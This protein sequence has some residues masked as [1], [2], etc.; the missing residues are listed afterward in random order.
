[1]NTGGRLLDAVR[2]LLDGQE[3]SFAQLVNQGTG[4]PARPLIY[5]RS[6]IST[7]LQ[8]HLLF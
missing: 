7:L 5:P 8:P 2:E 6:G 3:Y 4:Q 1:M